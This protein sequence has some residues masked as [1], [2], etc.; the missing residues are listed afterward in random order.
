MFT[1]IIEEIGVIKKSAKSGNY[2]VF[3]ILADKVCDG[4]TIGESVSVNGV[5]LTVVR[6]ENNILSFD[7]MK[8]TVDKTNLSLLS[9]GEKVNL[10]RALRPD[11]RLNGHFVTGH[12]DCLVKI[13]DISLVN[14]SY[15][16]IKIPVS[17]RE[18]VVEKGSVAIEG[19]S[20]TVGKL[21][22]N[23]LIVYLIPHTVKSTNLQFKKKNDLLNLECDI[24]AKY[25]RNPSSKSTAS[26]ITPAFLEE[27]GFI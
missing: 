17:L 1:G 12:I 20:L 7:V 5:C 18:F 13:K 16:E 9:V 14:E 25:T 4:L 21:T 11:S 10:E 15:L 19:I 22:K 2:Q 24:L 6:I 3:D 27:H 23:G 26:R 8:E